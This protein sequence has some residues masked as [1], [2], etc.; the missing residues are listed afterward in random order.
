VIVRKGFPAETE[1]YSCF[2]DILRNSTGLHDVLQRH[3]ITEL[4]ICGAYPA[5][6][7][8]HKRV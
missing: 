2:Y 1:A 7:V 5:L 4:F 8:G 3:K 6:H